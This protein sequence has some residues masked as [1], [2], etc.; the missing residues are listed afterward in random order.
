MKSIIL[1]GDYVYRYSRVNCY[2]AIRSNNSF[3]ITIYAILMTGSNVRFNS[4]ELGATGIDES[5]DM[6]DQTNTGTMQLIIV[7]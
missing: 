4:K 3:K 5:V 1:V 6:V 7:N 2:A